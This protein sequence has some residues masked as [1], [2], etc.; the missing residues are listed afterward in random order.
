MHK[1]YV[2]GKQLP[3]LKEKPSGQNES[4]E[5]G[6]GVSRRKER[7]MVRKIEREKNIRQKTERKQIVQSEKRIKQFLSKPL[8]LICKNA[9]AEG[10]ALREYEKHDK[11]RDHILQ[12][13]SPTYP[14][15]KVH[16]FG[17]RFNGLG[18]KDSD[19]DI[20]IQLEFSMN[21]CFELPNTAH[22][23]DFLKSSMQQSKQQRG[24]W[25]NY[26]P[27][28]DA[29]VPILKV[30][31]MIE[32][33]DCDISFSNP[34][35]VYNTLLINHI[36]EMQPLCYNMCILMKFIYKLSLCK[37]QFSS[38]N[39]YSMVLMVIFYLQ[40]VQLLPSIKTLQSG[41]ESNVGKVGCKFFIFLL[42]LFY[43]QINIS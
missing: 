38:F 21:D 27:I 40:T 19:I 9:I 18:C 29:K 14:N 7:N 31:Y 11:I 4:L 24:I 16:F 5:N 1:K 33:I 12:L 3:N 28:K 15:A 43:K 20:F 30:R 39:T 34:F 26:C 8:N 36:L 22:Y 42:F 23:I 17:S 6:E 10:R 37:K 41:Q 25:N 35:G 32:S 13:V 2:N